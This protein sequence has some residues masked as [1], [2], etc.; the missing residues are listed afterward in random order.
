MTDTLLQ[1]CKI[2]CSKFTTEEEIINNKEDC[3]FCSIREAI[4]NH[5]NNKK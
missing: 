5:K 2:K 1:F 3:K 4:I